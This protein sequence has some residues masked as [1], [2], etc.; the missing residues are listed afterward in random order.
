MKTL[1]S[2]NYMKT[3]VYETLWTDGVT[4]SDFTEN[5]YSIEMPDFLNGY[6]INKEAAHADLIAYGH[7]DALQD[8]TGYLNGIYGYVPFELGN[9][10]TL[11]NQLV[12]FLYEQAIEN[13]YD[14]INTLISD[15]ADDMVLQE[16]IH[17]NFKVC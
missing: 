7:K 1:L 5:E 17:G 8:V 2:I 9:S 10:T 4:V 13:V 16:F 12:K 3:I 6:Y 11:A 15:G 14:T